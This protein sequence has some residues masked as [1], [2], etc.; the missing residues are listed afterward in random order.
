MILISESGWPASCSEVA[1]PL[2]NEWPKKRCALGM[3]ARSIS[4]CVNLTNAPQ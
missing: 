1:P 4:V 2:R 3:L